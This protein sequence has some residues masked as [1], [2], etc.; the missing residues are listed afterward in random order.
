MTFLAKR[1]GTKR[2]QL[3][4]GAW[5]RIIKTDLGSLLNP[6][7]ITTADCAAPRYG[8]IHTDVGLVFLD[9]RA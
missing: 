3:Q 5:L 8:S 6:D 4:A 2:R 9:R 1:S 7:R